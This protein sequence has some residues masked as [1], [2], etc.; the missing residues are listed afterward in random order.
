MSK[1]GRFYYTVKGRTFC[2]EPIDN[3]QGAQQRWGDVDPASKKLQG[4]YGNDHTGSIKESESVITPENG[5]KNIVTLSKG[6]SPL[7]YIEE[8]VKHG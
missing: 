6:A 5:F 7:S 3:S 2:I 8:L 4:N 1:T